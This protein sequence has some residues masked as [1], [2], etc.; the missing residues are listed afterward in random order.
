MGRTS[1]VEPKPAQAFYALYART[2]ERVWGIL[3]A[4]GDPA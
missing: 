4:R 2:F 1:I 3:G